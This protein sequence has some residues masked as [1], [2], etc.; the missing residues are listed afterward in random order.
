MLVRGR[1]AVGRCRVAGVTEAVMGKFA[2]WVTGKS[3]RKMTAL[4]ERGPLVAL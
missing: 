1:G 3:S 2:G 4:M